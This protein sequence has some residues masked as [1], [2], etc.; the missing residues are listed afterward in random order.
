VK[1]KFLC[2]YKII[3][4]GHL[5]LLSDLESTF[6]CQSY[7]FEISDLAD[8]LWG[9]RWY[10]YR[11]ETLREFGLSTTVEPVGPS[12]SQRPDDT[13]KLPQLRFNGAG[14]SRAQTLGDSSHVWGGRFWE[15]VLFPSESLV[16]Q[17]VEV[18]GLRLR[19]FSQRPKT[20]WAAI[21]A[22]S[23]PATLV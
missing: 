15:V 6:R 1:L 11:D 12:K 19:E 21:V 10:F 20:P 3:S 18:P 2:T 13:S 14:E 8:S 5:S 23:L 7:T 22:A 16:K 4:W 9:S 17:K